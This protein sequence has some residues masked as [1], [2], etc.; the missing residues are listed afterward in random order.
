[1]TDK[2]TIT[3]AEDLADAI[4]GCSNRDQHRRDVALIEAFREAAVAEL[5]AEVEQLREALEYYA[6]NDHYDHGDVPCH[7]YVID[8]HGRTAR[9]AL[10]QKEPLK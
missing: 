1:M 5:Q 3:Q 4:C 7:I 9:A 6:E 2:P 10:A 8:D